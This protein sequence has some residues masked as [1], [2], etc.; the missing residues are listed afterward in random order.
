MIFE[1]LGEAL[2]CDF[3]SRPCCWANVP[4]PDDQLDWH[5]ANGVPDS[6]QFQNTPF[7]SMFFIHDQ[8]LFIIGAI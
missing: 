2:S 3:D 7:P 1:F 6:P 8:N 4:P 5:L